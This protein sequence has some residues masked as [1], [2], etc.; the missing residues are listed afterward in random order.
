[1]TL[2]QENIT[3]KTIRIL[4][5]SDW[6]LGRMLYGR[7]REEESQQFLNWLTQTIQQQQID[8]LLVA[9]DIFDNGAPANWAVSQYYRFLAGISTTDCRH[10]VI[11]AGNHDSPSFLDAS[12][13]LLDALDIHVVSYADDLE[14][15]VITL[16]DK[17]GRPELIVCAVPYLHD[18]DLRKTEAGESQADKDWKTLQGIRAHY[19]DVTAIAEKIRT[20]SGE[21][22]PIVAMGHL[23][24]AGGRVEKEDGVREFYVGGLGK[25]GVDAFPSALGYVALG[26]LH[27]P[28]V[29]NG[30]ET[31]RY[32]GS[33]MP[34][35]FN[36]AMQTKQVCLVTGK[37]DGIASVETIAVPRFRKLE[38]IQGD[39]Q[40]I[41]ERIN[42]LKAQ[43]EP[44]WI[45]VIYD[46]KETMP[47]LSEQL[48]QLVRETPIEI[49]RVRNTHIINSA[50]GSIYQG[51]MLEDLTEE[52]VFN[53]LLEQ[54]NKP[55][56][57][58]AE[59]RTLYQEILQTVR[60][61]PEDVKAAE[62]EKA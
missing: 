53:R 58:R 19:A 36:E 57:E 4:H 27:V 49:L 15:E 23:F 11:T 29:V 48:E 51:E 31:I 12:S 44:V 60:Q 7:R 30:Q 32:S 45:E 24:T 21:N 5:T 10:V 14:K 8:V 55:E 28:Q 22:I 54:E 56:D 26:H 52:D 18:R 38:S 16:K 61:Q 41:I 25:V 6:H 2:T 20:A 17:T 13:E 1:M 46:G 34:M 9:G 39:W 62:T 35:G 40:S 37:D 50:L 59:L 42:T 43:Q 47:D 3:E 33:P